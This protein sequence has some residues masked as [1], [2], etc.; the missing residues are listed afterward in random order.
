MESQSTFQDGY[1]IS[2]RITIFIFFL[3]YNENTKDK[4]AVMIAPNGKDA[5]GGE[6]GG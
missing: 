5:E 4:Q 3:C 2:A 6:T 1:N